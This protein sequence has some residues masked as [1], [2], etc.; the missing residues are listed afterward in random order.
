MIKRIL[1]LVSA[2]VMVGAFGAERDVPAGFEEAWQEVAALYR[3]NA[4]KEGAVAASLYFMHDGAVLKSEHHGSNSVDG[5]PVDADS[6]YHWASITK[7]FTAV[8]VMQLRDRGLLRLEDPASDYLPELRQVHNPFGSMDEVTLGRLLNHSGGFRSPTFPWRAGKPWEPHEPAEW[9][10]VAAMMPYTEILFEP[11]SR[12]SYSNPG[13]SILGRVVEVVTGDPIESYIT[14]N[15]LMPLGMTRS[16]FDV[17]PYFLQPFK[18]HNY[19]IRSGN[20][21]DQGRELDT[22]ATVAN[23]GLN[24]TVGDMA[25]WLNFWLGVGDTEHHD[26]VLSRD[27]LAE[28]HA[29]ACGIVTGDGLDQQMGLSFFIVDHPLPGGGSARYIGHTGGQKGYNDYVYVDP[30]SGSAVI[31]ANNTRNAEVTG[32]ETV[33]RRTRRA[34]FGGIF[35]LFRKHAGDGG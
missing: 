21:E 34:I 14:K 17:T 8:A 6:I 15:I 10:Q 31:F 16:Y 28:M 11:G 9:S 1:P 4:A 7:T 19:F 18:T 3:E 27:S 22:G 30:V 32:D 13:I 2:A 25:K 20:L 5:R 23:G 29:P 24:G 12:C 35:P 33:Y 26:A